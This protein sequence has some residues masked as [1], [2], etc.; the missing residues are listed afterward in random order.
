M[1]QALL[2]IMLLASMS[3]ATGEYG[4]NSTTPTPAELQECKSLGISPEKCTA[5]EILNHRN[6]CEV[7]TSCVAGLPP[8]PV[9]DPV[10]AAIMFG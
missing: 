8:R 9:I 1:L 7:P 10:V 4:D 2:P 5:Q 6:W 3:I